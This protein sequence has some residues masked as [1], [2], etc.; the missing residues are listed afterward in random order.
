[1]PLMSQL[2]D[3]LGLGMSVAD[4]TVD[5][6]VEAG[7]TVLVVTIRPDPTE[8]FRPHNL[9]ITQ[10]QA[11]RLLDDL[12]SALASVVSTEPDTD[13]SCERFMRN[14]SQ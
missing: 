3:Y 10:A 4:D 5:G 13:P 7:E 6:I 2:V 9:A 14:D 11:N 1:M 12:H 8:S